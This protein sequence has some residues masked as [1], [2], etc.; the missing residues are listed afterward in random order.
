MKPDCCNILPTARQSAPRSPCRN[1]MH[2]HVDHRR[3]HLVA[4]RTLHKISPT[5]TTGRK[6]KK[7]DRRG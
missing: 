5:K 4:N 2:S 1:W 7:E 6:R 3:Q